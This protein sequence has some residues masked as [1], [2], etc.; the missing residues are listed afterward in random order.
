MVEKILEFSCKIHMNG[1]MFRRSF[2]P[3]GTSV[4]VT[5]WRPEVVWMKLPPRKRKNVR[6]NGVFSAGV[7]NDKVLEGR[8]ENE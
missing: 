7:E 4:E 5:Q 2:Q 8:S 6:E 3:D 1:G